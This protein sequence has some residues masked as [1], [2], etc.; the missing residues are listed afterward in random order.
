LFFDTI[1]RATIEEISDI[2]GLYRRN[3]FPPR[4][5]IL[6]EPFESLAGLVLNTLALTLVPIALFASSALNL[7]SFT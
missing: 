4:C 3:E 2:S 7:F 1:N 5:L 6:T